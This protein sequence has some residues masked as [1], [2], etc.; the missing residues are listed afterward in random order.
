[1]KDNISSELQ[2]QIDKR[3][4]GI[5][6]DCVFSA[7]SQL[8][9]I[10]YSKYLESSEDPIIYVL[11]EIKVI[12]EDP[13]TIKKLK[14]L[15]TTRFSIMLF[16]LKES[17]NEIYQLMT[18]ANCFLP[19]NKVTLLMDIELDL[20]WMINYL[21]FYDPICRKN[22]GISRKANW[23]DYYKEKDMED[24]WLHLKNLYPKLMDLARV[25]KII[26]KDN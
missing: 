24:L 10:N 6:F 20:I 12:T 25:F 18:I 2:R 13:S 22:Y 4:R 14:L 3:V 23:T 7:Y 11:P 19:Q 5:L 15:G 16:R 1:M 9:E 8:G 26:N 21:F 17:R